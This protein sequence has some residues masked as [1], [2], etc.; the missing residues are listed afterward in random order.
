LYVFIL[1]YFLQLE[2]TG[3]QSIPNVENLKKN[4]NVVV[5]YEKMDWVNISASERVASQYSYAKKTMLY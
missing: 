4:E 3:L 5:V 2:V 1:S